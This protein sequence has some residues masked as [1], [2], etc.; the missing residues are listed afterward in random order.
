M[1]E[2]SGGI[3]KAEI[4]KR[5]R[6]KL[7]AMSDQERHAKSVA[8]GS[9]ITSSP[10]FDAA[11]VVMLYLSMAHE[12]DTAPIALRCWQAG[13][14]VVV[15]KVSWDQRRMLPT[16]ITSLTTG[17]TVTGAGVREP[18]SG[19]P[20]PAGMID[21][22]IVPGMGFTESGHRIGRGMGFYDRF[23][24]QGEFIGLS[25]GLGFEEQ[26]V[27]EIPMLEHDM[28][29]SMLATDRGIRRFATNCIHR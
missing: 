28:A 22:V 15:P 23:L 29:L 8:A 25:C 13:K 9:L 4:R 2:L 21:L 16:E 7:A 12:V 20:I 19:M 6:G 26:I 11:Q 1:A 27:A 18:V 10:E 5:L 14:T 3:S 24:G 17:L